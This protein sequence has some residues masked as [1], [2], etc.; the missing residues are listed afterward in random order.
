MLRALGFVAGFTVL[1]VA[2]QTIGSFLNAKVYPY[3]RALIIVLS[4]YLT[5]IGLLGANKSF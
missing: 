1:L 3:L 4:R 5:H 2:L